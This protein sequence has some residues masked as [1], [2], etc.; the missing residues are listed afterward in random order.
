MKVMNSER[1]ITWSKDTL[2]KTDF[3]EDE[4]QVWST[5]FGFNISLFSGSGGNIQ[6]LNKYY[7]LFTLA[8]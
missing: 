3:A 8:L 1:R 4:K 2:L 5:A 7:I 6:A